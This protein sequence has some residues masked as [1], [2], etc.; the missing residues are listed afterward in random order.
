MEWTQQDSDLYRQLSAIAVPARAEQLATLLTLIPF[1]E[2]EAFRV[3]EL[4]SGEGYLSSA[5]LKA[6]PKAQVIALDYEATMREATEKRLSSY[7]GRY[8]IGAFD[9][10]KTDWFDVLN[11]A[12]VVVSSLCIHHLDDAGKQELFEAVQSRLSARG[13]LLIADLVLPKNGRAQELFA[14]TWD[15]MAESASIQTT[16]ARD[17]FQLFVEEQWNIYRYPDDFDKPSP[18]F[19]QLQWLDNAGFETVDVFWMQAGHA[20]YG[21]YKE[22]AS[23]NGLLFEDTLSI[24]QQI[25]QD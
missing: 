10:L 8:E 11:D 20:I 4:A 2:D 9:I 7:K 13:A 16:L 25:L 5:I 15:R 18:M 12:D 14:T 23:D 22:Q 3:V 1:A 24:A 17:V 6:F 21:G 19:E